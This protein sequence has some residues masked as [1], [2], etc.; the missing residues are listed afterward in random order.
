MGIKNNLFCA[1]ILIF[2]TIQS[3]VKAQSPKFNWVAQM[4]SIQDDRGTAI[5]LDASGNV[6]TVGD[7]RSTADFD[8]G[9]EVSNSSSAGEN[10]IFVQKLDAYGNFIW[11]RQMGG[12]G[13]D[14][15]Q[16]VAVDNNGNVY[17][18][19]YFSE[20]VDFD[21][22]EGTSEL[23]SA[24][25]RDVFIQK[26]DSNGNLVWVKQMGGDANDRSTSIA[27]DNNGNVYTTGYFSG[28]GDY[29]PGNGTITFT[30]A[31]SDDIFIQK[32][33]TD[34]ELVW[35]RQIGGTSSEIAQSIAVDGSGN[36]Y[37]TG[38]F[39]A[40]ADFN[41]GE[42]TFNLTTNGDWDI[43]TLKLN[44]DG[45]F[46]WATQIGGTSLDQGTSIAVDA[47]SNVYTVGQFSRNA[48]F[49]PGD[50]VFDLTAGNA[51]GIEV[52]NGFVQK[53]DTDGNFVWA[54]QIGLNN[55]VTNSQIQVDA[56]MSLYLTGQFLGTID[57]NPG[58][59]VF[60]LT[61]VGSED[62][63]LLKLDSNGDF[64]WTNQ[65]GGASSDTSPAFVID[66]NGNVFTTGSLRGTVDFDPEETSFELTT[67]GGRDIFVQKLS[68]CP[69]FRESIA[70]TICTGDTY[71]LGSQTLTEAGEYTELL[72]TINNCDST[73]VLTLTIECVLGAGE[74][75]E[76]T[77]S[78]SPN[79]S[80][81]I[82]N[83][84]FDKPFVGTVEL[85]DLTGKII[86]RQNINQEATVELKLGKNV[87]TYILNVFH[88]NG[89]VESHKI[90]KQ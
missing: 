51:D 85:M 3:S 58:E 16:A 73:I 86:S 63:Y 52:F 40:E 57:F 24:G 47:A 4:G 15:A 41:P 75:S 28:S 90:L 12:T 66:D 32:L 20:T 59:G 77:V 69:T 17:T 87:G 7:F 19:G 45:E 56:S 11:A 10:D 72:Q 2:C 38:Y 36:V 82:V 13:F 74:V 84:T 80:P 54:K 71:T 60:N 31:D 67:T 26:L 88:N 1:A 30:A 33:D 22:G 21:P 18:T 43:F 55:H 89:K 50:D 5:T 49:D 14:R 6:Y 27:V 64:E 9:D 65:L 23:T 62:I 68:P 61:S 53:L 39:F 25:Q 83:I 35:V 8:P 29:D 37:T 44:T 34:G 46:V 42:E 48:D 76:T 79:P 70:A 78:I 81:D